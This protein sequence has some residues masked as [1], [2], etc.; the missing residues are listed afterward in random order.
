[1]VVVLVAVIVNV[2]VL[3][4]VVMSHHYHII[5]S[6]RT[7]RVS[8]GITHRKLKNTHHRYY[9][10]HNGNINTSPKGIHSTRHIQAVKSSQANNYSTNSSPKNA[11]EV[12]MVLLSQ[13]NTIFR[14]YFYLLLLCLVLKILVLYQYTAK[15]ALN[16]PRFKI[17]HNLMVSVKYHDP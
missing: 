10:I 13:R 3:F 12:S 17:L 11:I 7:S 9:N 14:F 15:L 2:V 6:N 5:T 16:I 4:A 1:V 8:N